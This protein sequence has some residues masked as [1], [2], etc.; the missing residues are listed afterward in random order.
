MTEPDLNEQERLFLESLSCPW[1]ADDIDPLAAP[2]DEQVTAL[3]GTWLAMSAF[4]Q[5][6][7]MKVMRE[8]ALKAAGIASRAP[9]RQ[10]FFFPT[11]VAACL[12]V[13]V[14]GSMLIWT[15]N[16]DQTF[17]APP[18]GIAHVTLKDGTQ[19]TLSA[20]G[21]IRSRIGKS[22][23]EIE[24]KAGDAYFAVVHDEN[25]PLT[26]TSGI[27]R[28]VDLGTEFNVSEATDAYRVTLV[29]GA[30]RVANI[31][32]GYS[33]TLKPGQSYLAT[34]KTEQIVDDPPAHVASWTHGQLVVDD[35]SLD[36]V[37]ASF[38]RLTGRRFIFDAPELS[39]LRLSGNIDIEHIDRACQA[40]DALLPI[41]ATP[42]AQGDIHISKL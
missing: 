19:V 20:G 16:Q 13:A 37:G 23:R 5:S 4:A 31:K 21:M 8:Q 41:K 11:A 34:T 38:A 6:D 25:R 26:V 17:T 27:H 33:Q 3:T 29:S 22:K 28:V 14:A 32:T 12:V 42:T 10:T 15:E 1:K 40:L 39:E 2:A 9:R 30:L 35:A 18:Q 36:Q 7:K 24:L